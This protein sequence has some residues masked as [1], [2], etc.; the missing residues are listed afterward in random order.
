MLEAVQLSLILGI[1][2]TY[3]ANC[4]CTPAK[5]SADTVSLALRRSESSR[6]SVAVRG[7]FLG[8]RNIL[9]SLALSKAENT[10]ETECSTS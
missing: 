3:Q 1:F 5:G 4:P 10:A 7:V 9:A 6:A 8:H 2:E